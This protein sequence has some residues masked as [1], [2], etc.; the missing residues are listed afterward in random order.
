MLLGIPPELISS[1]VSKMQRDA[2]KR[3]RVSTELYGVSA[4]SINQVYEWR[5]ESLS[6]KRGLTESHLNER[7]GCGP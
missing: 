3:Q 7:I 6:G 5:E 1:L 4:I 2:A